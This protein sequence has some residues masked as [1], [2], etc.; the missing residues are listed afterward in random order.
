MR[1]TFRLSGRLD[2]AE[3][4]HRHAR[5]E[6]P[7]AWPYGLDR[8]RAHGVDV[9]PAPA[10]RGDARLARLARGLGRYEW[11]EARTP[12]PDTDVVLCWDERSGVPAA[13][14]H[15][16]ITGVIWLTDE[17]RDSRLHRLLA[18]GGLRR[19]HRVWALSSAQLPVLRDTFRVPETRLVHL[20]FGIDTDFFTPSAV[21]RP[22]PN[23]NAAHEAQRDHVRFDTDRSAAH[24]AQRGH[25]RSDTDRSAAH[26]AQRGHIRSDTDR[27]AAHEAQ[28]D[29][30]RFDTDRSAAREGDG[31]LVVSAGN[32]RHRD[33]GTLLAAL[34]EARRKEP[35][36]RL[37]L[38]TRQVVDVPPEWGVRHSELS[39]PRMRDLYRRGA[40]TVVAL[41]PNLH[42]SGISVT[43]EAMA[44]GRPVVVTDT[45]GMRDYVT[46]GETGLLV[47]AGD[48]QALAAAVAE[49]LA[50]PDRA[51]EMG[52]A[53]RRD[54]ER[55]FSTHVQAG[56]LA[57][58]AGS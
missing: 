41:R 54:V 42:V 4:Q 18:G 21:P 55:R 2:A 28:R 44:C 20:P 31:R 46:H 5:G 32:D 45:P 27:S 23:R 51:R 19:A 49:L 12:L 40:V 3:W 47:P 6:V 34:A 56:H 9:T 57:G 1:V 13:R 33:H 30:P 14:S 53:A 24:E 8:M 15:R 7:D 39:H 35:G 50:D 43:L 16:V 58:I 11:L 29:H 17:Q 38:A 26:E 37:E 10:Y 48:G 52:A 22:G 25:I 36:L